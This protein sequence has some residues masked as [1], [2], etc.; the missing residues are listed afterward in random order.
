MGNKMKQETNNSN[1]GYIFRGTTRELFLRGV[2]I[3]V[4]GNPRYHNRFM[5]PLDAAI[6]W[7]YTHPKQ[8]QCDIPCVL[9]VDSKYADENMGGII[10]IKDVPISKIKVFRT[11]CREGLEKLIDFVSSSPNKKLRTF[12]ESYGGWE[13]YKKEIIESKKV[14]EN[15]LW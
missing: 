15:L 14:Q 12:V 3:A 10:E 13:K 7:S 11:D 4:D 5:E 9:C 8:A 1:K 2:W 6:G